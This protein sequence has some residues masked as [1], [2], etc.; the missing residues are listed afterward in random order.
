MPRGEREPIREVKNGTV[1][2]LEGD[3]GKEQVVRHEGGA[4]IYDH[5]VRLTGPTGSWIPRER[6]EAVSEI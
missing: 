5:W 4:E 2:Y 3:A 1:R 6:I